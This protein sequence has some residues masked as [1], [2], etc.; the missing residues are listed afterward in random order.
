MDTLKERCDREAERW[1]KDKPRMTLVFDLDSYKGYVV[2]PDELSSLLYSVIR[3]ERT[4]PK[5]EEVPA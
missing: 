5:C 1:V 2:T 4:A 3:A